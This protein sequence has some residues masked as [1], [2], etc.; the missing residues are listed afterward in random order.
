MILLE[1]GIL[2]SDEDLHGPSFRPFNYNRTCLSMTHR[3]L[4]FA[5]VWC[6][7]VFDFLKLLDRW[8]SIPNSGF[9]WK[10]WAC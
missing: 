3:L 6:F 2:Y 10:Y 8:N 5:T 7:S 1:A 4:P 9:E